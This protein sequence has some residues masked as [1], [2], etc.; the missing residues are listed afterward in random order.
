MSA[1]EAERRKLILERLE[2]AY[3]QAKVALHFSNP[4]E[5]LVAVVLSAQCMD[6]VV[7]KATEKLF[8][9]YKTLDD[10]VNAP[11]QTFEKELTSIIFYRNKAKNIL[12]SAKIVKERHEGKVPDTM[13]ELLKLPGVARKTANI[14]LGNAYGKVEGIAV[15]THVSRISQRLRLVELET[16][17]GKQELTFVR[18]GKT[19]LDFKKDADPVK[20]EAQLMERL[21]KEKWF[22]T[23]YRI[24]D[25]GRAI[26]KAQ[27]PK[28]EICPLSDLCP[29]SRV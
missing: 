3:P 15:D 8:A 5:L 20:I 28:C 29:T 9:K 7:N 16:I 26:C 23:T 22:A 1:N 24:I 10:Y 27:N 14:I 17:G 21:P 12:A 19:V 25:H 4:W 13:E 18:K 11:P 2:K 6:I